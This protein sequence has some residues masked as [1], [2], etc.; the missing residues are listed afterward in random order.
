LKNG[1]LEKKYGAR[2][3]NL[4]E[5]ARLVTLHLTDADKLS[6]DEN[7]KIIKLYGGTDHTR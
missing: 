6:E 5:L 7:K 3:K 1:Y 2:L 4:K